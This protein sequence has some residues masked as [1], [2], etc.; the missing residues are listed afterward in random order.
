MK[1]G[2][3]FSD[4][5]RKDRERFL[6]KCSHVEYKRL[7]KVLKKCRVCRAAQQHHDEEEEEEE[8]EEIGRNGAL[9]LCSF[10][11]ESCS[12][13]DQMFFTELTKEASE[14]AGCF[15]SRVRRLLHPSDSFG[16]QRYLWR[17]RHCFMDDQQ[18]MIQ[19]GRLLLD[20]ITMNSI[21]IRK[22]LKKYDKIHRSVNGRNFKTKMRAEHL[23]L[24][25]SPWLIELAAFYINLSGSSIGEPGEF[26][27]MFSCDL[28]D[29]QPRMII[30]L[31][32]CVMYEYSLTCSICLEIVFN[33]YALG[34]GHLF[35]KE[36]ACSAASVLLFQGLKAA[37]H[38][39]KCPVCREVG[40]YS[41][42]VHMTGLDLL[43]KNRCKDYW[44]DRLRAERAVMVKQSKRYWELQTVTVFGY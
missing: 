2:E 3:A 8:E 13:C 34:C 24:L 37:S 21:A 38:E 1:F 6:D 15:I 43:V 17:L 27:R 42:A 11:S 35:C 30:M 14:I 44:K 39:A 12:L 9:D 25:Q 29:T 28:C 31:S 10:E 40:V 33:P 20:Y 16:L 7:K 32:D 19:E 4:Y 26:F 18:I 5:L 41:N 22:I 36:C 23:E